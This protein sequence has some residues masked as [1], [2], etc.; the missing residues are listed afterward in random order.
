MM[1][2]QFTVLRRT[3]FLGE[4]RLG[5]LNS[6]ASREIRGLV[7]HKGAQNPSVCSFKNFDFLNLIDKRRQDLTEV[8]DGH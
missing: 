3:G 6:E 7:S 1:E 5:H 4:S 2:P 8:M